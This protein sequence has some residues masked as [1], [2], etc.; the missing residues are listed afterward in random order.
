MDRKPITLEEAKTLR[1]GMVLN[2]MNGRTQEFDRNRDGSRSRYK[3]TSVKTLKR[4]PDYVL[5]KVQ[6]GLKGFYTITSQMIENGLVYVQP[7]TVFD[8]PTAITMQETIET[9]PAE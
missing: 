7:P 9:S 3:V 5:I 1:P 6:W 2:V 4:Q 8:E